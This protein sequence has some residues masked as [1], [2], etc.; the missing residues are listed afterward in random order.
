MTLIQTGTAIHVMKAY[1]PVITLLAQM[2]ASEED[3]FV[4]ESAIDRVKR[5]M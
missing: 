2:A 1:A 4:D 3:I 5:M